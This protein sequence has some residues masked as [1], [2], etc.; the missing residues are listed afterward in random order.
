VKAAGVVRVYS[1]QFRRA[2]EARHSEVE[3]VGRILEAEV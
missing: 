2:P 3:M 1:G